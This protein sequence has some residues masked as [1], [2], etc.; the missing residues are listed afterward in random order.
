MGQAH[1][2]APESQTKLVG[3]TPH[4][5]ETRRERECPRIRR[6]NRWAEGERKEEKKEEGRVS[7][8]LDRFLS[9]GKKETDSFSCLP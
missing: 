6:D 1:N 7:G 4:C 3:K 8:Q 5:Q 2:V 9:K